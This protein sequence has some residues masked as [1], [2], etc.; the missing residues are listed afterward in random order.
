MDKQNNILHRRVAMKGRIGCPTRMITRVP[1]QGELAKHGPVELSEKA[2]KRLEVL[3]WYF[4]KSP[5]FSDRG[6]RDA[7]VTC[8]HFGMH[9]SQ[10]YRWLKKYDPRRLES[11][12][13]GKTTPKRKRQPEYTRDLVRKVREIREKDPSYSG[14][15][16]R[17]ILLR[18]MDAA[19]VPSVATLGRLISRENLF[20]RPDTK[21]HRKRSKTAKK[22]HER[23][24]KPAGLKA[25][26]PN[27]VV[28]YDMKHVYLLGNKLYA[29][30][31]IDVYRKEAVLHIA[32]SPSSL[33][34]KA[35]MQKVVARFGKN[36]AVVNDNGS[37]NMGKVE[38][39]LAENN[40]TQYWT[41][42]NAP[43]EKPFI[44]RFI[45]TFQKE[46]LDYHYEPMNATELTELANDWLDKYHHYRPHE[47]LGGLTPAEFSVTLG[48]SIPHAGSVL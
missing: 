46:C 17:P 8:R 21:M 4:R 32:T 26:G 41:H 47:S 7:S 6:V 3:D 14:K 5:K 20:F 31:A 30:A 40:I 16:I 2:K 44:E 29:F 34:S 39:F 35:A 10:F 11:L 28:E 1:R 22:A 13:P 36:I 37:E 33:N 24:R 23:K 9:R 19:D 42:P 45:G 25:D 12:E 18:E 38:D 15:K 27:R 48:L 43:K